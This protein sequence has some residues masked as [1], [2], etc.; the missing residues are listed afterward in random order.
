MGN[1]GIGFDVLGLAFAE[2]GD[3]VIAE[4]GD[5]PGVTIAA[6]E[7][8]DGR[9]PRDPALNTAS[10]AASALLQQVGS[11]DGFALTVSKGLPL[12][13]G[14]G[15]SAASAVAAVVAVNA[16]LDDPL[17]REDLLAACMEGEALVSGYHVDN[18]GPSLL[19]GI[20]L[21]G[22]E[23]LNDIIRL[24]V[25]ENMHF[26]L[27]TPDVAVPTAEARAVLPK[28]IPLKSM[29]H[30]TREV[31]VLVDAL[32][33]G[34]LPAV[35]RAMEQDI[36]VEPARA[37]LMP[38]LAEIRSASKATGALG[39]VISGAGPTLC[40]VCES[41]TI[42]QQVTNA[43]QAVYTEAGIQCQVRYTRVDMDGA[44]VL[45]SG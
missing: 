5:E 2:P 21:V 32:Y 8:D 45:T 22:G 39:L 40:A 11:P 25:P 9:L 34:D 43:M 29:I 15:S 35:A 26:A 23:D 1:V 42:A 20:L 27:V 31:A 14:L 19:G 37:H 13:S 30:Q 7:G 33:R 28:M 44:R 41:A 16:L 18:I 24:P 17:P 10:V 3:T 36:V 4:R 6:I 12:A 38:R